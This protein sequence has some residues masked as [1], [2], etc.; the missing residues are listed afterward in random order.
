MG[1]HRCSGAAQTTGNK[2]DLLASLGKLKTY[3]V[4]NGVLMLVTL[5][6]IGLMML[7]MGAG[8]LAALTEM[9]GY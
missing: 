3:F 6:G 5:I 7:F 1:R 9:G 2:T 4:I 8:I